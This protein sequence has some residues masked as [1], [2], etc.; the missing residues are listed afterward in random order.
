MRSFQM[1]DYDASN[2]TFRVTGNN[3]NWTGQFVW[4][5]IQK[6]TKSAE[7]QGIFGQLR[8]GHLPSRQKP[9]SV[10]SR[11]CKALFQHPCPVLASD[12]EK[13][14][15]LIAKLIKMPTFP[16]VSWQAYIGRQSFICLKWNLLRKAPLRTLYNSYA[17]GRED[18]IGK[19]LI[20]YGYPYKYLNDRY[21]AVT[22]TQ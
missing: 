2:A 5:T 20:T 16:Y 3:L 11:A 8:W 6:R 15:T 22:L 13:G 4:G 17:V 19:S 18:E 1:A 21:I 7:G 10:I 14:S 12:L 9:K